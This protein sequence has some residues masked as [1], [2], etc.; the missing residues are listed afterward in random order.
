MGSRNKP[1][2][3]LIIGPTASGKTG[4]GESIAQKIPS[5]YINADI[6]QF[7]K[8]L[9]IGTAK[10][11]WQAY[12]ETAH[13]FDC[14]D[15]PSDMSSFDYRKSV[16]E[17]VDQIQQRKNLPIIVGGSLFYIKSLFF[18]PHNFKIDQSVVPEELIGL[19]K[20]GRWK[21]LCEIDPVRAQQIHPNDPY[22]IER[23]LRIWFLTGKKPSEVAPQCRPAF[24][25]TIVCLEPTKPVLHE[26][27][28]QR[29]KIMLEQGWIEEVESLMGTPWIPFFE[30]KGLIG[31]AH[32]AT[33]IDGG[34]KASEYDQLRETIEQETRW[35]A[36]RQM[37]FLRHLAQMCEKH[38]TNNP[39]RLDIK[40]IESI[41]P[42]SVDAIAGLLLS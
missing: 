20:D 31:Y 11:D 34:K 32:I 33:W 35:Y 42:S 23:A 22:R 2:A 41:G 14:L 24:D 6:G 13:L 1:H 26:R 8:P 27:I 12:K 15:E 5:E 30:K 3:L 19:S 17:L 16:L 38:C 4:F 37:T 9:S 18:P 25:A 28:K 10:P 36:K 21:L 29:T 39:Y 40:R 7:Y